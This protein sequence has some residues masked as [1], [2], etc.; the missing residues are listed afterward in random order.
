MKGDHISGN[1][2]DRTPHFSGVAPARWDQAG[3]TG[4]SVLLLPATPLGDAAQRHP[5]HR[6]FLTC[7]TGIT[8]PCLLWQ[9]RNQ[10]HLPG[11]RRIS[12][13]NQPGRCSPEKT[14]QSSR[15]TREDSICRRQVKLGKAS[16]TLAPHLQAL[17]WGKGDHL[18]PETPTETLPSRHGQPCLDAGARQTP[19]PTAVG[20][21]S[22]WHVLSITSILLGTETGRG[23][24][25]FPPL[26]TQ[27]QALFGPC[28]RTLARAA[29]RLS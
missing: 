15:A 26:Q 17:P 19:A 7:P 11:W 21:D 5:A 24:G 23:M 9:A 4:S 18:T 1:Q 14:A 28:M 12:P 27:D 3:R 20:F 6:K 8:L 13:Y 10:L 16:P 22:W 2:H 29:C 25:L